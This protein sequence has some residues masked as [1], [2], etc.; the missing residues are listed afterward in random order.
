MKIPPSIPKIAIAKS[1][2]ISFNFDELNADF[3]L[4]PQYFENCPFNYF[5]Q[6][7]INFTLL[8]FSTTQYSSIPYII[9][10]LM[11]GYM[12]TLARSKF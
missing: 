9:A 4:L 6:F 5:G 11:F 1:K 7:H 10:S 12:E 2:P 8:R 3:M